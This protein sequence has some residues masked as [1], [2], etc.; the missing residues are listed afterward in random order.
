MEALRR[1]PIEVAGQVAQRVVERIARMRE[2]APGTLAREA[3]ARYLWG[4]SK[5]LDNRV[6]AVNAALGHGVLREKP[7][8]VNVHAPDSA[9]R[10]ILFV[11]NEVSYLVAAATSPSWRA[12]VWSSGFMASARRLREVGGMNLHATVASSRDGL[13]RLQALLMSGAGLPFGFFGDLDFAGMRILRQLRYCFPSMV[14]WEPGYR[15]LVHQLNCGEGHAPEA[16]E[17]TGQTD[18]G[19]TG[20]KLA[21][22][23]LL[24]AIRKTGMFV[25]QEIFNWADSL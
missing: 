1:V 11:E 6:D 5:L 24:P 23:H 3:S 20:C 7:L 13:L 9:L 8:L 19:T 10:E 22:E 4:L 12:L 14:A 2:L 18:P 15:V 16:G 17:K 25:D 21:D